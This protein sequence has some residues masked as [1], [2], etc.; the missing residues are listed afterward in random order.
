M[1]GGIKISLNGITRKKLKGISFR[2]SNFILLISC[3]SKTLYSSYLCM[4]LLKIRFFV[5][6]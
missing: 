4:L 5:N 1:Y 2:K 3:S 6:L